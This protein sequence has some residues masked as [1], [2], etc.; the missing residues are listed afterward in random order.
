MP[1]DQIDVDRDMPDYGK[2]QSSGTEADQKEMSFLD[3]LEELRWHLVRSAISVI[4]F[5]IAVFAAGQIIFEKVIL[6]PKEAWFIT[7]QVICSI[8]E[9]LCFYPPEFDLMTV[10][11]GEQFIVHLKVSVLLGLVV[12]FPYIFYEVWRF[13][14]PG[15]YPNEQKA[16]RGF[17]FICSFLFFLGV[18]FGYFIVSPFAVT[19]LAGYN[20]GAVSS[21]S[22]ASF[23]NYMTMFTIP[24]GVVFELPVVVYFLSRIGL[25]YPDFMKQYRRH[26]FVLILILSAIITPPDVVTQFLIGIPLYTLY[27]LSI[28]ICKRVV[29]KKELEAANS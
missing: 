1:L 29:K 24:T 9:T 22:L 6:A 3:H 16:A 25:L 13:I 21:P 27:E 8:S 7:Y 5:A 20:V 10:Q 17:V 18:S 19:F 11:L 23:V 15:L 28:I 26:A 2:P 4:I 12:A 14:R